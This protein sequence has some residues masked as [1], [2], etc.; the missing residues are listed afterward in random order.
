MLAY[1]CSLYMFPTDKNVVRTSHHAHH[2]YTK[3]VSPLYHNQ[4]NMCVVQPA[5]KGE[6]F[7]P[8]D[9]RPTSL[10]DNEILR[11]S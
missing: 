5:G 9:I 3:Y 8:T 10:Y 2:S 11:N 4:N 1:A 6:T 7:V